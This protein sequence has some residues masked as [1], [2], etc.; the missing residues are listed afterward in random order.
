MIRRVAQDALSRDEWSVFLPAVSSLTRRH[1]QVLNRQGLGATCCG[2]AGV[3]RRQRQGHRRRASGVADN[4]GFPTVWCSAFPSFQLFHPVTI[5][6]LI[7]R[8]R[9]R[10]QVQR[11]PYLYRHALQRRQRFTFRYDPRH[12]RRSRI[13]QAAPSGRAYTTEAGRTSHAHCKTTSQLM[14]ST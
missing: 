8:T 13:S 3:T 6:R 10:H 11:F 4:R 9:T 7:R 14:G 2:V 5:P 12:R 1:R